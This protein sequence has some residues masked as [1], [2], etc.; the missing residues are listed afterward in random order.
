[1]AAG[2]DRRRCG[3]F[4]V[5]GGWRNGTVA[6]ANCAGRGAPS[7]PRKTSEAGGHYFTDNDFHNIGIGIIRHNVVALAHLTDQLIKSGNADAIDRA[8][9]ATDF[10]ALGRFLIPQKKADIAA[11]KTPDI[12]KILVTGP[13]FH[14]GSQETLWDV[15]DHYNKG[16]WLQDPYLDEDIQPEID[17]LVACLASLT[18]AQYREQG[19]KE[20]ARQREI[21]RT[22]RPQRDTGLWPETGPARATQP[23]T[24]FK[25]C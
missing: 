10:S 4:R 25:R 23:L 9:V 7:T 18:S 24:S 12:R 20:L 17:D 5:G 21:A 13:Y 11:F 1:L 2:G 15:I 8:A 14:D 22:N 19:E 3:W 16:D 6:D